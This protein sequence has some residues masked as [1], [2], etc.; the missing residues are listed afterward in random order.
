MRMR[1]GTTSGM[2]LSCLSNRTDSNTF[3]ECFLGRWQFDTQY[4]TRRYHDHQKDSSASMFICSCDITC[5][6]RVL[7]VDTQLVFLETSSVSFDIF[8]NDLEFIIGY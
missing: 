2:P 8:W 7:Y 4:S 3:D 6:R 1:E 5:I